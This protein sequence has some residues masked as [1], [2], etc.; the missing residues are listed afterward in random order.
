MHAIPLDIETAE[1]VT[2]PTT[3]T[4]NDRRTKILICLGVLACLI[5]GIGFV[6]AMVYF[7][8]MLAKDDDN[9]PNPWDQSLRQG[10]ITHG[11]YDDAMNQTIPSSD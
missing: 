8:S 10:L 6:W 9:V 11:L 2:E 4:R 3:P 7:N 1:R 5:I